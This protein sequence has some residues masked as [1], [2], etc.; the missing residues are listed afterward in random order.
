MNETLIPGKLYR[1]NE[2]TMGLQACSRYSMYFNWKHLNPG[3]IVMHVYD[4]RVLSARL[5]VFCC[6][7]TA[8][9]NL[10]ILDL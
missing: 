8:L 10:E 6:E 4:N 5:G 3:E 2:T 1:V 7:R 9:V